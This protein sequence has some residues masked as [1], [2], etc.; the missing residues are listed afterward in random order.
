M[1]N[2][3]NVFIMLLPWQILSTCHGTT[4]PTGIC[5]RAAANGSVCLKVLPWMYK[6]SSTAAE[7]KCPLLV[8]FQLHWLLTPVADSTISRH[9]LFS[10]GFGFLISEFC[11]WSWTNFSLFCLGCQIL[12]LDGHVNSHF[13]P[14]ADAQIFQS[15]M[16]IIFEGFTKV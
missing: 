4:K 11:A 8:T 3:C 12:T 16:A 5:F 10:I 1:L 15:F 14:K 7:Y 6:L 2:F 13:F 9:Y